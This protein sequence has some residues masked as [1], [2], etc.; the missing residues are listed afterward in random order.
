MVRLQANKIVIMLQ[1]CLLTATGNG[2]TQRT[3]NILEQRK[4]ISITA[5]CPAACGCSLK[6]PKKKNASVSLATGR[7]S[8]SF[9]GMTGRGSMR[10][11]NRLRVLKS[12]GSLYDIYGS[13]FG[14]HIDDLL[15]INMTY[16][17]YWSR[18]ARVLGEC[19]GGPKS[20]LRPIIQSPTAILYPNTPWDWHIYLHWGLSLIHI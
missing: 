7:C 11:F 10:S 6:D 12:S 19:L 4:N 5:H 2:R 3:I 18:F 9:P 1:T 17:S 15:L 8:R 13:S 14:H 16:L 20:L